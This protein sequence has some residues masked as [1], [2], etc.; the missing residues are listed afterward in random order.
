MEKTHPF[1]LLLAHDNPN[2]QKTPWFHA[3]TMHLLIDMDGVLLNSEDA[4]YASFHAILTRVGIPFTRDQ[5]TQLKGRTAREIITSAAEAAGKILDEE[6]IHQL[7]WERIR[8]LPAFLH[9]I[10]PH[11][12]LP[13]LREIPFMIITNARRESARIL[14][15]NVWTLTGRR[16]FITRS[17]LPTGKPSPWA[18]RSV[19]S[20]LTT[21]LHEL[22]LI[23]DTLSN[24][25]AA[26]RLGMHAYHYT[27]GFKENTLYP[28]LLK[29]RSALGGW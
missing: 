1:T 12:D 5:F 20:I 21:P 27:R 2:P 24:V 8:I 25:Q 29:I 3:A 4:H 11:P 15:T 18:Y 14:L 23:D 10:T 6:A 7:M 17:E 13:R 28:L 9:Q 16:P 19:S 22:I 26:E